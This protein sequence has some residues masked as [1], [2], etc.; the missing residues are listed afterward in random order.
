MFFGNQKQ[1]ADHAVASGL[2][3]ISYTG[4]FAKSGSLERDEVSLNR[5]R[6]PKSGNF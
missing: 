1:I 6:I 4:E 5:F 3:A 2:P